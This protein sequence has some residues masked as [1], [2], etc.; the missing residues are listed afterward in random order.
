MQTNIK[1]QDTGVTATIIEAA[2]FND[3]TATGDT[4]RTIAIKDLHDPGSGRYSEEQTIAAR[5]IIMTPENIREAI[6]NPVGEEIQAKAIHITETGFQAKD[7]IKDS[8][9]EDSRDDFD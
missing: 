1:E 9:E 7:K 2:D 6:R 4:I 3:R 5:I 8:A